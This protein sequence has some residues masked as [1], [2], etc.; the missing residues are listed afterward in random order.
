MELCLRGSADWTQ[1]FTMSL[2]FSSQEDSI[3]GEEVE[4]YLRTM[5]DITGAGSKCPRPSDD[6]NMWLWPETLYPDMYGKTLNGLQTSRFLDTEDF[7]LS[8]ACVPSCAASMYPA[9][10]APSC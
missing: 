7:P 10:I 1:T 8:T 9:L 5:E 2:A 3:I 6:D 4:E